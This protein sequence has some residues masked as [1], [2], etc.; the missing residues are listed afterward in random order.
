MRVKMRLA[1][2]V[3]AAAVAA[4]WT[5]VALAAPLTNGDFE[6]GSLT[7]WSSLNVGSNSGF[8]VYSGTPSE[9]GGTVTAPPQGTYAAVSVQSG[10][11]R[12]ILYQDVTLP[13]SGTITLSLDVYYRTT[14]AIRTPPTLASAGAA[15]EQFRVDVLNPNAPI[16]S[17]AG[18]DILANVFAT[19]VGDL[20]TLAP[21][22]VSVDLSAFAGQTVR[23]RIAE[24]D[25]QS[26]FQ[27]SVDNV[28]IT[29]IGGAVV[30]G[31]PRLG[32]CAAA[33]NTDPFTG[34]AVTPDSFINLAEG[35][36][37]LDSDYTGA[38]PAIYVQGLGITC[39]PPPAGYTN[40]GKASSLPDVQAGWYEY[41]ASP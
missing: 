19:S 13:T 1:T 7:G 27:A 14:A 31:G 22:P 21:T 39:D 3:C 33:G 38:T 34:A 6:T 8:I 10:P 15:N 29:S 5:T 26:F 24:V 25:N 35:Q 40:Q 11:G 20:Q 18:A 36:P 12:A 41:W 32:Y 9:G 28:T 4:C 30:G 37:A 17:L 23:L 16:D 2:V